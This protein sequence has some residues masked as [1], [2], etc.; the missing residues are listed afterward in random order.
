MTTETF[1]LIG[2]AVIIATTLAILRAIDKHYDRKLA[3]LK[4]A[5]QQRTRLLS[6]MRREAIA[7]MKVGQEWSDLYDSFERVDLEAHEDAIFAGENPWALYS[8]ELRQLVS[9]IAP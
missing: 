7:R 9:E 2:L 1:G 8:P 4:K 5:T 6:A 3:T